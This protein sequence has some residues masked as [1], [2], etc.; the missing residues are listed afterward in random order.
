MKIGDTIP[1]IICI[2]EPPNDLI[3]ARAFHPDDVGREGSTLKIDYE[4]YL[5]NQIYPPVARLCEP[6]E[7]TDSARIADCLGI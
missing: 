5:S 3:A 7:E 6:I 4:W 1:Y 2:S